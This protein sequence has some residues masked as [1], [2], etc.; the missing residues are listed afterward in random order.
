[1]NSLRIAIFTGLVSIHLSIAAQPG[2]LKCRPL[3]DIDESNPTQVCWGRVE[4]GTAGDHVRSFTVAFEKP[5][6]E[7]P[8][9]TISIDVKSTGYAYAIFDSTITEQSYF[10][11]IVEVQFRKNT[12]PVSFSYIAIGRPAK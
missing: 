7:P 4:L 8:V 11:N 1:M 9:I 3:L 10:G 6:A 12:A 5:F 2:K